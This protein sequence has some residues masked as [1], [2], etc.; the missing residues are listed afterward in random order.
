MVSI[1]PNLGRFIRLAGLSNCKV[2]FY[3]PYKCSEAWIGTVIP[4]LVFQT[5]VKLA[6]EGVS[7]ALNVMKKVSLYFD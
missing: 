1:L 7:P 5:N 2:I 6:L 4:A 3:K